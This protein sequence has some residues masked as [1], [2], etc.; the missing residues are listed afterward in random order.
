MNQS[1]PE[2]PWPVR[3]V[4]QQIKGWID[5]LGSVWIE[6]QIVQLNVR[7]GL[8]YAV[9]RDV[10]EDV[11]LDLT[12]YRSVLNGLDLKEGARVV[13]DAKPDFWL[14][15][16]K[17]SLKV[18][19]IRL[20]GEGELLARLEQLKRRLAA[21]GL[22]D[23]ALKQALPFA[24][25]LVGLI[26]GRDSKAEHDVVEVATRR[27][28]AVRF[29]V[30]EV[31]VQ[32]PTAA[33][34]VI[35]ALEELD[36]A[37]D[38][39]VIVIARGGGSVEDLLPFSDESLIRAV[40]AARTPVVSAIGHEP[41]APLLDLVAD[42]RAA[43]PT[44][45][46]KRIVPD[47]AEEQALVESCAGRIRAALRRRLDDESYRLAQLRSRPALADPTWIITARVAEVTGLAQDARRG[48]ERRVVAE[49]A[50][51]TKLAAQVA[52]LSP[53]ATLDRGYALV[54]TTAGKL[55]TDPA[56]AAAGT[57]LKVRVAGG[58]FGATATAGV[59]DGAGQPKARAGQTKATSGR[60]R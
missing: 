37:A 12:I 41:D 25:A 6:G 22:F 47:Q 13:V 44:E 48:I 14:G 58:M 30:R 51:V 18:R 53:H 5:R 35:G 33:G 3:V 39:E 19:E 32:G 26:C 56:Q 60:Q 1:S 36:Q 38:V 55:V 2:A 42:F 40:A 54:A 43:T 17:L 8:A 28:P 45:A 15:R 24:P 20:A 34:A 46:G 7:A 57:V 9:L 11:S 49:S 27:W 23:L 29:E 10:T 4:A 16:G 21:E 52:A 59:E 31:A 50:L